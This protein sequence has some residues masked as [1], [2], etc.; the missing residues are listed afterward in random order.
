VAPATGTSPPRVRPAPR[1]AVSRILKSAQD[2][3]IAG[4]GLVVLAPLMLLIA[5][6][7]RLDSRGPV[8]YRQARYG[9][10]GEVFSLLKF[11]TLYGDRCDPPTGAFKQVTRADPRVTRVG[12]FLR[13][14]SLDE[15]PQLINVLQGH[16]SIVGPRPHALTLAEEFSPQIEDYEL[17]HEVKPG[18]TGWAQINGLRGET[19][20]VE[21]MA[22]RVQFDVEY[23]Q[24]SSFLFDMKIVFLTVFFMFRPANAY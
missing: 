1:T 5:L 12:R 17:R 13:R 14:T 18:I 23:V 4:I 15:L 16:M 20:T 3:L 2:G 10:H 24:R 8:F 19:P 9:L 22:K 21:V 7:I 11:R 6:A